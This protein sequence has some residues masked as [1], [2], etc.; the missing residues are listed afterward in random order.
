M[1][2]KSAGCCVQLSI[3]VTNAVDTY[4]LSGRYWIN[5][6]HHNSVTKKDELKF[7]FTCLKIYVYAAL[8]DDF[9][10]YLLR[11]MVFKKF[12]STRSTCNKYK[13]FTTAT[14]LLF[15]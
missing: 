6:I 10:Y 14:T 12:K 9:T 11:Y 7:Y 4:E 1:L 15:F 13:Y 2:C 8:L 3:I 5:E